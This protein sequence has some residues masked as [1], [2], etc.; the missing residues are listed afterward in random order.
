MILFSVLWAPV[1]YLFWL[2]I[3]PE[4]CNSGP[5]WALLTGVVAAVFRFFVPSFVN[6][7]GFGTSRYLSAFI[8]YAGLPVLFP[9]T[10]A[11]LLTH[12]YP[13]SGIT[14]FT[15]FTLLALA[16]FALVCS[17]IW[18]AQQ[19]DVLRLVLTPLMWTALAAAFHPL[20][21]LSMNGILYKIVCVLG[22]IGGTLLSSL[23]WLDFFCNNKWRGAALLLLVIMPML[24]VCVFFF[25][26]KQLK[27][28][29]AGKN[30]ETI[31]CNEN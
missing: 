9:L 5:F 21:R 10:A 28:S 7:Y 16:P 23:V 15:G 3:R 22:I 25:R 12:F 14:D 11:L 29:K 1:F 4:N 20:M 8:D 31:T 27:D 17:A 18:G 26:K 6:A 24:I 2:A 13:R 30:L 19:K